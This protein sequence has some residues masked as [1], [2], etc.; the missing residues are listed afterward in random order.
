MEEENKIIVSCQVDGTPKPKISWKKGNEN[1]VPSDSIQILYDEQS[2]D[3]ILNLIDIP[4]ES[5]QPIIYKIEVENDFGKA[6]S[7]AEIMQMVEQ[8]EVSLQRIL[9]APRVT[10]LKA[11]TI[12]N[13]STLTLH[14]SYTGTPEPI[15]KWLKNG[16]ELA[17]DDDVTILIENGTTTLTVR[18][19]DRK[20]AGKYEI[21]A[22]NDIGESKASASIMVSD[23]MVSDELL[24]PQFIEPLQPKTVLLDDVVIMEVAVQSHPESS[25]QW[26]FNSTP[27]IQ[28]E[29]KRIHVRNN[30]SVL[31]IERFTSECHGVY[32]CRAENV[33]G[34]VTSSATV[35]LVDSEEQLEE[36]K[37]Y[38]S[39]RFI[40]KLKPI[41]LM[42][43]EALKLTCRVVGNPI[44]KISWFHDKHMLTPN[45]GVIITQDVAGV[46]ELNMPEVFIEDSGTYCCKAI[47]KFGK[48]T[49]KTNVVIEG[50][51]I[52]CH[53]SFASSLNYLVVL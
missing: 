6:I 14:S 45:K 31:Y 9:R 53:M 26:F 49:T 8:P 30:R 40:Q 3:V 10:P 24:P 18:N 37:E 38:L 43:G 11:Q 21:V 48:S 20:R 12:P 42:D 19:V 4:I 39:P 25:F 2:G 7:K 33:C 16:K 15:I 32:T 52:L 17:I 36:I 35:T 51:V 22:T 27:I 5:N 46:C 29:F 47:N 50:I 34:S 44:P 41:Q 1:I 23:D 13:K 28:S